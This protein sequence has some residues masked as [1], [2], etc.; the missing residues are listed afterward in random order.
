MKIIVDKYK[1]VSDFCYELFKIAELK[2]YYHKF[3]NKIYSN[4]QKLFLLVYKQ[5]RKFTYEE[6]STDLESNS[7]LKVYLGF[8]KIPHYSTLIKF[9][10]NL[11]LQI[12]ERLMLAFKNIIA[13]PK[14]VAI[15][16]TGITLDNASLH[17]CKRIG[18]PTKK[19]PFMKASFIVDIEKYLIL[20]TKLRKKSRHDTI[21]AKT[22]IKKFSKHYNPKIFFGDRGYDDEKIFKLIFEKL[23]A[24]PLILQRRIDINNHRRQGRYRKRFFKEFDYCQYLE[25]NKIETL[26]SMIKRRFGSNTKTKTAKTQKIE[27]LLRIIAFNIDR[28]LRIRNKIILIFIKI[29]RI[30]H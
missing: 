26:N 9:A 20:L 4:F 16:A 6:L 14:K 28:L 30:S 13:K 1:K 5:F 7:E 2:L 25:R 11:S 12:I 8:K 3:S 22:M 29:T 10:K 27:I 15:D 19:R 21:D 18:L 17:Y 23:G 24:Y